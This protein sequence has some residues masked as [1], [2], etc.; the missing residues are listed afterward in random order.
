MLDRRH[1]ECRAMYTDVGLLRKIVEINM[2]QVGIALH[3]MYNY[4][5]IRTRVTEHVLLLLVL[6][7]DSVIV[8]PKMYDS[9]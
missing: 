4:Y 8:C 2:V 6:E 9:D 7:N 5:N 1:I 3:M